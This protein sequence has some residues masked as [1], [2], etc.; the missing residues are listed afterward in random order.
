MNNSDPSTATLREE[1]RNDKIA[2][3][4]DPVV[5]VPLINFD[6]ETKRKISRKSTEIQLIEIR[7]DYLISNGFKPEECM[8]FLNRKKIPFVFT[9]RSH[10]E[11]GQV[12]MGSL[13][14]LKIIEQS[15]DKRPACIDLELSTFNNQR[16]ASEKLIEDAHKLNI[17]VIA[18]YHNF[19][20]TPNEDQLKNIAVEE[21]STGADMLKIATFVRNADDILTLLKMTLDVRKMLR[22]PMAVMGMGDIGKI[23]RIAAVALGSDLLFADLFGASAPGQI[24]YAKAKEMIRLLYYKD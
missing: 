1:Y 23:T 22:K 10:L 15:L 13:E 2:F 9:M 17:C 16:N 4:R 14:R 21:A 11:S 19:E 24:P 5:C 20:N 8:G 3:G 6:N 18:S 12:E 7:A